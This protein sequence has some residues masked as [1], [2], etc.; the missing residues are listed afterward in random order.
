ALLGLAVQPEP[1]PL[2]AIG[3]WQWVG[4]FAKEAFVG[5]AIGFCFA[6]TMW[7]FEAAGQI[8]DT[9][10]GSSMAQVLDPL[11][12]HQTSL[13]GAFLAR[14]ASWVFMSAGGLMLLVGSLMESYAAW[15]VAS[16]W[17]RLLAAGTGLFEQEF[18]R[19]L[20]MALLVAAPALV[21]L[22]LVDGV[23]GLVNRYAQQLNVFSLS[24]SIKAVV[25]HA[26]LWMQLGLLVQ[27]LSE[28]LWA[29]PGVVRE[30]L[31]HLFASVPG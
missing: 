17:P 27:L 28:D 9:K 4:L 5:G 12:G 20:R 29:R 15:P 25:A 22:F 7:A 10:V 26:V 13:T 2:A 21:L 18:G 3:A 24:L 30:V 8:V 19:I 11:S 16:A 14:L 1:P 23:L 6:G 31:R